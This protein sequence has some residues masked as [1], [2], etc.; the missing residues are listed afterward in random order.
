[1]PELEQRIAD[2]IERELA[3]ERSIPSEPWYR[4]ERGGGAA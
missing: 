3:S 4:G 1:V 2:E